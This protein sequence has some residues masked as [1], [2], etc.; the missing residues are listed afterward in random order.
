MAEH[1]LFSDYEQRGTVANLLAQP[2]ESFPRAY[3]SEDGA[4]ISNPK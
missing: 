3:H 2:P 4:L 1:C